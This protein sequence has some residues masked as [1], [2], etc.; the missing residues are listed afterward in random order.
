MRG[1]ITLFCCCVFVTSAVADDEFPYSATVSTDGVEVRCGPGWEYYSTGTLRKG[2]RVEVYRHEP[3]GWLAVRP[4]EGS[5]SWVPAR[6]L[7]STEEKVAR[8]V[9]DGAVAWVGSNTESIR[10]HKWQIRLDRGELV[11][12][13]DKATMAVG[14]GFA[15]ETYCKIAPPP[16]EFRWI[17]AEHAAAPQSIAHRSAKRNIELV[18]FRPGSTATKRSSRRAVS[19]AELEELS[20]QFK[21]LNVELSLLVTRDIAEWNLSALEERTRQLADAARDTKYADEVREVA[22]RVGE[23]KTLKERYEHLGDV[24]AVADRTQGVS[25]APR[26]MDDAP[27]GTGVTPASSGGDADYFSDVGWLMPVHSAKRIAPPFALLDDTG[28]VKCYVTP[29]PGLNLRRYVREHVSVHGSQRDVASLRA[30]L[31]TAD[32]VRKA[33][34]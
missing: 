3:G 33:S 28:Q 23:F 12:V 7:E 14:P 26:Q 22:A 15:Q 11:A 21:E 30:A 9:V 29:S 13:L 25:A 27:I 6:Q 32:R 1:P 4:P 16:G 17:H 2:D 18:D 10:Q 34:K 24:S 31:V 20:E 8:V 5:H 19:A